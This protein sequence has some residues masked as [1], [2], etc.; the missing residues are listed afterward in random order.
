MNVFCFLVVVFFSV[1]E[2]GRR[3]Q[4]QMKYY[5]HIEANVIIRIK[6]LSA[7]DLIIKSAIK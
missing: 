5:F 4:S 2:L 1:V 7:C 6:L 3:L